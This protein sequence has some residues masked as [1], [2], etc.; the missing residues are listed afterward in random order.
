[1]HYSFG[2]DPVRNIINMD[3]GLPSNQV[4]YIHQDRKGDVWFC[5]DNGLA[6]YNGIDVITYGIKDG[7]PGNVIFSAFEDY[8][9]RLW[10]STFTKG[11][12]YFQNDSLII[13][14]FNPSLLKAAGSSFHKFF[15]VSEND[16]IYM[17]NSNR[18]LG[19]FKASI[20]DTNVLEVLTNKDRT[21]VDGRAKVN[22]GF[23]YFPLEKRLYT[24]EELGLGKCKTLFE[25][26]SQLIKVSIATGIT[27][28]ERGEVEWASLGKNLFRVTPEGLYFIHHFFNPI[29]G[30]NATDSELWVSLRDLGTFRFE[31]DSL[32][33]DTAQLKECYFPNKNIIFA[34]KD[35]EDNYWFGTLNAGAFQVQELDNR[36]FK[37]PENI[38]ANALTSFYFKGDTVRLSPL[39][40]ITKPLSE[41]IRTSTQK[42]KK[43]L[44]ELP[45][46]GFKEL[47]ANPN[48]QTNKSLGHIYTMKRK[49]KGLALI[50]HMA[51][52]VTSWGNNTVWT[53]NFLYSGAMT[54]TKFDPLGGKPKSEL[55]EASYGHYL[56]NSVFARKICLLENGSVI[57][58]TTNGFLETTKDSLIFN[59][60]EYGVEEPISSV[61]KLD[62][63]HYLYGTFYGLFEWDKTNSTKAIDADGLLAYRI[64]DIKMDKRGF[65]YVATQGGG[66]VV[67]A[68]DSIFKLSEL[69]GLSNNN[70]E[71]I[72]VMNDTIWATTKNGL[73][74]V[75]VNN[76]LE[77]NS[78][79]HWSNS[80][81]G[82]NPII[83]L[84]VLKNEVAF[85]NGKQVVYVKKSPSKKSKDIEVYIGGIS[86]SGKAL[87]NLDNGYSIIGERNKLV[88]DFR[89]NGLINSA[90]D[91]YEY[92][93]ERYDTAWVKTRSREVV[94][95]NLPFGEYQFYVRAFN[96]ENKVSKNT[97]SLLLTIERPYFR[98]I[99]FQALVL[100]SLSSIVFM[101]ISQYLARRNTRL[102]NERA[103]ISS[104]IFALKMQMNPHF[105]FNAL[106]S[107][108]YF[109]A[110]G[111]KRSANDFLSRFSDLIRNVLQS[112]GKTKVSLREELENLK[113]YIELEKMRSENNFIVLFEIDTDVA[114]NETFV[115]SLIL[116]PIVENAIWH[117]IEKL[118]T[119]GELKIRIYKE[120]QLLKCFISDNGPGIE[121]DPFKLQEQGEKGL[122][123]SVG[124]SNVIQRLKLISKMEGKPYVISFNN[125]WTDG[126]TQFKGTVVSLELP[127]S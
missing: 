58:C 41:D 93:L 48:L 106:N 63:F 90:F 72:V 82:S 18:K 89:K 92:K 70:V 80:L 111:K 17:M 88:I 13:P 2:Q 86:S 99:W 125:I 103:L 55:M 91:Y 24:F 124:L 75:Y 44:E 77:V 118:P 57:Y 38:E 30:I 26:C 117:G 78:T 114:T 100:I 112:A 43:Y 6:R 61:L 81:S 62:D 47:K 7:L 28:D 35:R 83:E 95:E 60:N 119:K 107:I 105:T 4:Y 69:N 94:Y 52:R 127:I 123:R 8:K 50:D 49:P 29:D 39:T 22:N 98:E 20:K 109:I 65:I 34:K 15:Y 36:V 5:T 42:F 40:N 108:Q 11:F 23:Y 79:F 122:Y 1:M 59:S 68:K 21:Y 32:K 19:Y 74:R 56:N 16:S 45:A 101:L 102:K 110:S 51:I 116:Q 113:N 37:L 115:P 14:P 120:A 31:F 33:L 87:N 126:T 53:D 76:N 25:R 104:N 84:G 27:L 64:E 10:F 12:F 97:A 73:N 9:G 54:R 85:Y 71:E 3:N 96:N 66:L 121:I 67:I 46:Y